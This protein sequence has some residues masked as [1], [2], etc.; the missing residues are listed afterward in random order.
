LGVVFEPRDQ[1]TRRDVLI[2]GL[3]ERR[4]RQRTCV[5]PRQKRISYDLAAGRFKQWPI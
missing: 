3:V 4:V 5:L 2:S 1:M